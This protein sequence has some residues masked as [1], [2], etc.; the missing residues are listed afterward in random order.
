MKASEVVANKLRK[1]GGEAW[2][3][4][5]NKDKALITDQGTYFTSDKLPGQ[6]VGYEIFD[7]IVE[8]LKK[9]P[10]GRA[11]K[12]NCRNSKVGSGQCVK[13]TVIYEIATEYYGKNEGESSFD[14]LF[15]IA[16]I[17]EWASI[18]KNERGYVKLYNPRFW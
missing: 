8:L 15:V 13:G 17:L 12:G 10:N 14:P 18:A 4:Q 5:L 9:Q 2:V 1:E 16:S 6:D 11:P 7:I 3:T